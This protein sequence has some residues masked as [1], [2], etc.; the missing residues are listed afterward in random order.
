MLWMMSHVIVIKLPGINVF[1]FLFFYFEFISSKRSTLILNLRNSCVSV[2]NFF[3]KLR[4]SL[5]NTESLRILFPMWIFSLRLFLPNFRS[6]R[7]THSE[8]LG[9]TVFPFL[10]FLWVYRFQTEILH[11]ALIINLLEL[12]MFVLWFFLYFYLFPTYILHSSSLLN[13]L[14]LLCFCCYFF[15]LYVYFP[16]FIFYMVNP[17][18]IIWNCCA[19]VT[20]FSLLLSFKLMFYTVPSLWIN[21]NYFIFVANFCSLYLFLSKLPSMLY[22]NSESLCCFI[23]QPILTEQKKAYASLRRLSADKNECSRFLIA[24]S[25]MSTIWFIQRNSLCTAYNN[26]ICYVRLEFGE[27]I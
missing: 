13:L 4:L 15:F 14:Q 24:I 12:S 5:A 22:I 3:F 10:I 23:L 1:P 8:T 27:A 26:H 11:S 7:Y 21:W 6:K 25:S 16:N 17:F 18:W 19:A 2:A 20:I 9:I